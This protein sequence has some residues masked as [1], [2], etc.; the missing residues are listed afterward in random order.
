MAA[1][2]H[3][4]ETAHLNENGGARKRI[5][6]AQQRLN[7]DFLHTGVRMEPQR[8]TMPDEYL[9]AIDPDSELSSLNGYDGFD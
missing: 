1:D 5:H 9:W 4:Q 6:S 2:R 8:P 7:P 3:V